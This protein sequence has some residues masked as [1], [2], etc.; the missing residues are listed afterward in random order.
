MSLHR[1]QHEEFENQPDELEREE[2][3]SRPR[4]KSRKKNTGQIAEDRKTLIRQMKKSEKTDSLLPQKY[5]KLRS[6]IYV[7]Q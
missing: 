2:M 4:R 3:I 6:N 7:T 1:S 5:F